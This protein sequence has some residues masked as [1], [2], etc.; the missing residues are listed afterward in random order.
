MVGKRSYDEACA[1]SHSLDLIGERWALLIVREL[2]YGPKRFTDLR[3][4][5][6]AASP[7]ILATRLREMEE[8]GVVRRRRLGPPAPAWVY[9]L[10]PWGARL[11]PALVALGRWG[12]ESP[13]LPRDAPLGTNSLL[14]AMTTLFDR[15][16]AGDWQATFTVVLD[17]ESFRLDVGDGRLGVVRGQAP[18]SAPTLFTDPATLDAMLW[19][20]LPLAT[21]IREGRARVT[22]PTDGLDRLLGLSPVPPPAA[23]TG[24]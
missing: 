24:G 1:M 21:A 20:D 13:R 3:A 19:D 22:G 10:T 16:A 4:S 15:A 12:A 5:M 14:L 11:E 6:P 18:A 9:E 2:L 7:N 8:A 17:D 23:T